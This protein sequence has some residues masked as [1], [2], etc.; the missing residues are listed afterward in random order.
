MER[1]PI[2]SAHGPS[3]GM[4]NPGYCPTPAGMPA[5]YAPPASDNRAPSAPPANMFDNVPG[6]EGTVVGGGGFLPPPVPAM[7]MPAPEPGLNHPNWQIPSLTEG[8]ARE[9]FISYASSKCCYSAGPARNGVIT[10][11]EPFNTYRYRLETFTE[12]RST[13]WSQ[14]PYKGQPVDAYTQPA[15][16][17]WDITAQPPP[18]FQDHTQNIRVPYTSSVKPCHLCFG[19]GKSPC[20]DCSGAGSK[21]CWVCNGSGFRSGGERCYHCNGRGRDNCF[22]C[23]GQG[24]RSCTACD[25]RGQILVFINLKVTWTNNNEAYVV[26]QTSGMHVDNLAQVSGKQL[27]RYAQYMVYPVTGFPDASVVAASERLVREHQTKFA[28]TSRLLQQR[29]TI[30]LIPIS[31]VTYAWKGRSHMFYVFGN[32]HKVQAV[33]YPATCCCAVM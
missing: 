29:Q 11:M 23:N 7:P 20:K 26:E 15:P 4:D 32:E 6:Y 2:I 12:S 21:I 33:D 22:Q 13:E 18:F 27:Y 19:L 8:E 3:Y 25:G 14:E 5:M 30:E 1:T 31:K 24:T 16:G 28:M 10:S 9:A 17:P